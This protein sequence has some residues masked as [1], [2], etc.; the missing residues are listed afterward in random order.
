MK[1]KLPKKTVGYGYVAVWRNGKLGWG[2][3]R[4]VTGNGPRYPN[5]LEVTKSQDGEWSYKCKI[6]IELVKGKNGKPIR[7]KMRHAD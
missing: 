1:P 5:H 6:T 4:Y 2:V 7:R 3:P